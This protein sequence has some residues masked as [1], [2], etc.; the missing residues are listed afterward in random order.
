[1]NPA[2]RVSLQEPP[3]IV[4]TLTQT[5]MSKDAALQ[6]IVRQPAHHGELHHT[7]DLAALDAETRKAQDLLGVGVHH[8]FHETLGLVRLQRAGNIRHGH[9]SDL[10]VPARELGAGLSLSQADA[11]EL[12]V[13]E[14]GVGDESVLDG[15]LLAALGVRELVVPHDPHVVV[16][17]VRELRPALDVPQGVDVRV[18]RLQVLVDLDEAV[19]VHFDPRGFQTQFFGV[20][21]A[22]RRR[23]H[24][25]TQQRFDA[26]VAQ[27]QGHDDL[28]QRHVADVRQCHARVHVEAA[29]EED[30]LDRF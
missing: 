1:M 6:L 13:H 24:V 9:L 23:Q 2:R 11:A 26:P 19:L 29:V 25:R 10:E 28:A 27:L 16:R 20:G 7:H 30:L 18:R 3:N 4:Q 15:R 22:S 12:G 14:D 5:R 8:G 21:D 17:H